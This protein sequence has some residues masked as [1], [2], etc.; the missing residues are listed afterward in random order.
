MDFGSANSTIV[1]QKTSRPNKTPKSSVG[2]NSASGFRRIMERSR[3]TEEDL[4]LLQL[5]ILKTHKK[6]SYRVLMISAILFIGLG[7]LFY[8]IVS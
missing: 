6:R 1:D 8:Y 2:A 5:N 4:E 3:L 7:V